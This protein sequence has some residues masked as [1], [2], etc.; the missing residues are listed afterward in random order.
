TDA[1]ADGGEL[2]TDGWYDLSTP[3]WRNHQR[4]RF[5]AYD[6][7]IRPQTG[8]MRQ[9][10]T[11]GLPLAPYAASCQ[12]GWTEACDFYQQGLPPSRAAFS[13]GSARLSAAT[14]A[15][16]PRLPP[17]RFECANR[18]RT[19]GRSATKRTGPHATSSSAST[20][21]IR[22]WPRLT[23]IDRRTCHDRLAPQRIPLAR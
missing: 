12:K 14:R 22:A 11:G 8:A 21:S 2:P 13:D 1:R 4:N 7:L 23:C 10:M 9:Y 20:R 16:P 5:S 6:R 15:L 3:Y 19:P 17:S 18:R